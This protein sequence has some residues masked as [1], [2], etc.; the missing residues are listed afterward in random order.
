MRRLAALFVVVMFS[1]GCGAL[2]LLSPC[3]EDR[4][5]NPHE[6]C[7]EGRCKEAPLDVPGD[8]GPAPLFDGGLVDAGTGDAGP[9]APLALFAVEP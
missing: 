8:A 2:S 6:V 1:F 3:A 7:R 4:H 9:D 5:C